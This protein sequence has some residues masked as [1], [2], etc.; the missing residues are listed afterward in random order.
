M[1]LRMVETTIHTSTGL[2]E[3]RKRINGILYGAHRVPIR[4]SYVKRRGERC[5]I[6]NFKFGD[7]ILNESE[8]RKEKKTEKS[9]H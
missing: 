4:V 2:T 6:L 5:Y 9:E 3:P 7:F 8:L 1:H